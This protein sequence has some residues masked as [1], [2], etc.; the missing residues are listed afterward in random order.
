VEIS[1]ETMPDEILDAPLGKVV[2]SEYL[3]PEA[4]VSTYED[5]SEFNSK[6]YHRE[7]QK[8]YNLI[9]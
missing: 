3:A 9:N 8:G 6:I 5:S 7:F 1:L 4:L 2:E